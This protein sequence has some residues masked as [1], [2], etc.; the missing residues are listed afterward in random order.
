MKKFPLNLLAAAGLAAATAFSV[1]SWAMGSESGLHQDNGRML[2]Y[3]A[4]ELDLNAEQET[5]I[6]ALHSALKEQNEADRARLDELRELMRAQ[7]QDFNA[8]EAQKLADEI[9]EITTRLVYSA[10]STQAQVRSVLTAEQQAGLDEIMAQREERHE[11]W[12]DKGRG[13]FDREH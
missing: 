12:R 11:R 3:L 2:A 10:T 7:R 4:D 6:R 1:G 9:G 5:E 13:R 8:G